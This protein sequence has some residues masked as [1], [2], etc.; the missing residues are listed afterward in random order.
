MFYCSRCECKIYPEVSIKNIQ[1]DYSVNVFTNSI[2]LALCSLGNFQN[3]EVMGYK[4]PHCGRIYQEGELCL[5]SQ[6]SSK[7][8][9]IDK[10]LIVSIKNKKEEYVG[11]RLVLIIPPKIIHEDELESFKEFNPY[12]DDK[13]LIIHRLDKISITIPK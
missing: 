11:N 6:I 9:K 10:F 3:L 4:C 5:R 12:K 7:I 1:A 8:D 13:Y 2:S